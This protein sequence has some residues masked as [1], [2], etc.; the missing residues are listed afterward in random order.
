M[1][2]DWESLLL[3]PPER[4]LLGPDAA[5]LIEH[6]PDR[7]RLFDLEWRLAEIAAYAGWLRGEHTGTDDER[8]AL[9]G[10]RHELTRAPVGRERAHSAGSRLRG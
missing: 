2:I 6:E 9:G 4:D 3:A 7:R 10:L 1:L 5:A 8:V